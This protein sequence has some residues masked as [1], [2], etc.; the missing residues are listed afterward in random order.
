MRRLTNRPTFLDDTSGW[1]PDSFEESAE[2]LAEV[3][4]HPQQRRIRLSPFAADELHHTDDALGAQSGE[5]EPPVHRLPVPTRLRK[6]GVGQDVR[7]PHG[8][9]R[10]RT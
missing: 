3:L 8:L 10:R 4:D 2:D 5:P 7:N 6:L 9:P 1:G